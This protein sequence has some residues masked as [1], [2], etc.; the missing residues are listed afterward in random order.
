MNRTRKG[1]IAGG[2][3]AIA[4]SVAYAAGLWP[5]LPILGYTSFCAG[6]V[7]LSTGQG[8]QTTIPAGPPSFNG[9]ELVPADVVA[10]PYATSGTP[11]PATVGILLPQL[12]QGAIVDLTTA[13]NYTFTQGVVWAFLHAT[14]STVTVTMPPSPIDGQIARVIC[15]TAVTST[16][17]VAAN[18]TVDASQT[19]LNNPNGSCTAGQGFAWRYNAPAHVWMRY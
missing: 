10:T 15:E 5:N 16:L 6:Q 14:Q 8:C 18:T 3:L 4:M 9:T 2:L 7:T 11:Q 1:L 19:L 13:A 17:T 12:G